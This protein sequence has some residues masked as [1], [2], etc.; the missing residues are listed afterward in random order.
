MEILK[1]N[2]ILLGDGATGKTSLVRRFV[3]DQFDDKYITTIGSKVTKKDVYLEFGGETMHMIM[4]LWDVLGQKG[5]RYTQALSFGGIEGALLVSDLTRANTLQSL[6]EYWIP[7]L[8]SV[9]G[10]LPMI[11]LGNKMD[12]KK[13]AEFGEAELKGAAHDFDPCELKF[14][15]TLTSAKTGE[16]VELVFKELAEAIMRTTEKAKLDYPQYIIDKSDIQN[17]KDVTDHI[18]ADFCQQ[19][20]GIENASPIVQRHAMEIGLDVE[21]PRKREL[22]ELVNALAGVEENFKPDNV[23]N[24]NRTKRLYLVNLF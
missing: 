11:F 6:R 9:T 23:V 17:L 19:F 2:I 21:N 15:H 18:I 22:V 8:V 16:N 12:L 13:D 7:S 5:Y 3:T 1:K 20:G 10:A 24:M 14:Q 4:L